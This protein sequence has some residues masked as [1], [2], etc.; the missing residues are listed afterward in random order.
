VPSRLHPLL[1]PLALVVASLTTRAAAA[2]VGCAAD[3][4]WVQLQLGATAWTEAQRAG[5]LSDLQHT[6]AAQG[7]AACPADAH[8]AGAA[9]ATLTVDLSPE[10]TAKATVDI[11]VRDAVTRK[12]VRRDVD[13]SRIPDDGRAAA[14]A[15]EADE[16][17]R[18]S[19]AEIALDTERARQ[20]QANARPQVVGS[21][22]QVM[23]PARADSGGGL[24]ARAAVE[25]FI[26]GV[27]LVGAD[28][29]GRLRLAPR[30]DLEI[31]AALRLGPSVAA[32][33][34]E[35]SALA[36]G[37]RLALLFQLARGRRTALAAGA[38]IDAGWLEFRAQST[39]G[40][41]AFTYANLL[42]VARL[43]VAGRLALGRT[44]HATAGLEVGAA[45]RGVQ[46]ADGGAVVA[47][48]RGAVVGATLGL[49]AP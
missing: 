15:I 37:G 18:A 40:A 4:P 48:A 41:D 46:A 14:I 39:G 29:V 6:L 5:V 23:A 31:A 42:T 38:G 11:E 49:E 26:G 13:L 16:L 27:T 17:L 10:D 35:V 47:R 20:A 3:G 21:V 36:A 25:H 32:P 45:L 19:W 1:A 24:G 9:L 2:T 44:V 33:D 34:G 7:I 22:E 30:V 12:R 43:R 8:P 28:A